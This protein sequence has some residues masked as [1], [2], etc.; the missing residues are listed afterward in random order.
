MRAGGETGFDDAPRLQFEP[1]LLL[2]AQEVRALVFDVDAVRS[3]AD[4]LGLRLL[5]DCGVTPLVVSAQDAATA[6]AALLEPWLLGHA[7]LG[8]VARLA[9][10][11]VALQ[12]LDLAWTQVA[13]LG[14]D[15]PD[16]A[17]LVRAQFAACPPRAH[18]E[19]RARA[20]WQAQTDAAALREMCDLLLVARGA[21]RSALAR[22][23]RGA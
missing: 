13:V 4:V 6:R 21:Y 7:R 10:T 2:R 16:L 17:L 22:A 23:L 20:H 14:S 15:W 5:R 19:V 3:P 8:V 12:E 18:L 11:E 9:Q 1:E